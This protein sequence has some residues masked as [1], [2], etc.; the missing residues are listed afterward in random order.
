MNSFD[1]II[2]AVIAASGV[3]GF[4]RGL[5]KELMSLVAFIAAFFAALWWGPEAATWLDTLIENS[6]LRSAVAYAAVFIFSLLTV[7]VINMLLSA[8]I[9]HTGL[10]PADHG[11]GMVF[12]LVRG[13]LIIVVLVVLAGYTQLPS[14][15]WWRESSLAKKAIDVVI[16]IKAYLPIDVASWLPY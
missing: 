3:L 2:L 15:P 4:V 16:G 13:G 14:E 10:S 7:G 12:G 5:I 8:L 11:L 9:A 1:Y 6:L